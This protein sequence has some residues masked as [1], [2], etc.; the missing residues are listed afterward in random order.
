MTAPSGPTRNFLEVPLDVAR[1]AVRV[2]HRGELLVHRVPPRPIDLDLLQHREAHPVAG[3]AELRDLIGGA[4][5]LAAELVAGE[6]DDREP[7]VAVRLVQPLQP[8]VLRR[9]AAL[10]RDVD[11]EQGARQVTERRGLAGQGSERNVVQGH[12]GV[13]SL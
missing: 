10:G 8:L 3:R 6:A 5:L 9:E 4:G 11:H 13:P 12:G 1:L 7:A 2:R